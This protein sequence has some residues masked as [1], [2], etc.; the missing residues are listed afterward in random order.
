MLLQNEI[1]MTSLL[2]DCYRNMNAVVLLTEKLL[3][4]D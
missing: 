3:I 4:L 1:G 2:T